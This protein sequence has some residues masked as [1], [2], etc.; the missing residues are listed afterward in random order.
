MFIIG[1]C[2]II[3]TSINLFLILYT[4][5]WIHGAQPTTISGVQ[6]IRSKIA[7]KILELAPYVF[8]DGHKYGCKNKVVWHMTRSVCD[9]A[10]END[11]VLLRSIF[12]PLKK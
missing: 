4:T 11:I 3:K 12:T 1:I 6:R 2:V 5:H 9:I 10:S 8:V 7:M